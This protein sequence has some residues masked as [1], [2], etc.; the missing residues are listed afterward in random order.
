MFICHSDLVEGR[1]EINLIKYFTISKAVSDGLSRRIVLIIL[2][3]YVVQGAV[4]YTG[5]LRT[6]R[7]SEKE[8]VRRV[9]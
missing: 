3:G 7:F 8:D 6:V 5:T 2:N 4:V 1:K 9:W